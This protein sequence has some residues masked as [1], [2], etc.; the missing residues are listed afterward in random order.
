[1]FR[2]NFTPF[3]LFIILLLN[4]CGGS[5]NSNSTTP[6]NNSSATQPEDNLIDDVLFINEINATPS[7]AYKSNEITISGINVEVSVSIE[8]GTL[9]KN[10]V[11]II[12]SSTSVVDGDTL[13]IELTSSNVLNDTLIADILIG[14]IRKSYS[15]TTTLSLFTDFTTV[16]AN[17][18]YTSNEFIITSDNAYISIDNGILIKNGV[19]LDTLNTEASIHDVIQIKLLS[20]ENINGIATSN[21]SIG[22]TNDTFSLTTNPNRYEF[23]SNSTYE[24]GSYY[25]D[26]PTRGNVNFNNIFGASN[27]TI[28]DSNMIELNYIYLQEPQVINLVP[29]LYIVKISG[30]PISIYSPVFDDS[31]THLAQLGNGNYD[32]IGTRL[33]SLTMPTDG[34]IDFT[35]FGHHSTITIYDSNMGQLHKISEK[36]AIATINLSEGLYIVEIF[37]EYHF[38]SVTIYSPVIDVLNNHPKLVNGDYKTLDASFYSL[39]MP[40][41]SNIDFTLNSGILVNIYDSNMSPLHNLSNSQTIELQNGSYIVKIYR[42]D[43]IIDG[44]ISIND[45]EVVA[46]IYSP[47]L[48]GLNDFSPLVNGNYLSNENRFYYFI[49]PTRGN[50]DFTKNVNRS[51]ISVVTIYST[52]MSVLHQ[53]SDSQTINLS[54]GS[55]I[56]KIPRNNNITIYSPLL[57]E[58]NNRPELVNGTYDTIYTTFYD[59][60][61]ALSGDVEFTK[62]Q[63]VSVVT[64]YDTNMS[65]LHRI[66]NSETISLPKGSYIVKM[67]NQYSYNYVDV[68]FIPPPS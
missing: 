43:A 45:T 1:M 40:N 16:K 35:E 51:D 55:Y 48:D 50:F 58:I 15:V 47:V 57:D 17:T 21:I 28:Y 7:T 61:M 11:V 62:N 18:Y 12:E 29:G 42:L 27:V 10:G 65:L 54:Q 9:I 14:S 67:Y 13:I 23:I 46:T 30:K 68:Y 38:E 22:A 24:E 63:G 53:I 32:T 2:T 37:N 56:V 6:T 52:N 64:I 25:L 31:K 19:E 33:Y 20:K 66:T 49:I 34:W 44:N 5:E 26:I 60:T 59:L 41:K 3:I 4:G 36:S 39:T 8:S